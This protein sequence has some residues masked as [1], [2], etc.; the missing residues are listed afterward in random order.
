MSNDSKKKVTTADALIIH[1]RLDLLGEVSIVSH[2]MID[3][4]LK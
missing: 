3:C 4:V 1:L 2:L